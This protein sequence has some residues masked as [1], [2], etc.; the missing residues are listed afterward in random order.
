MTI[1]ALERF[2]SQSGNMQMLQFSVNDAEPLFALIDSNREHLSQFGDNASAKYPTPTSVFQS[3][4]APRHPKR[5]RFGI[6]LE[7]VL[8]GSINLTP[9]SPTAASVGYW[10]G[11]QYTRRG[12]ASGALQ[13]M[14]Q[15]ATAEK[16]Y[17]TLTA[18]THKDNFVS[19][20]VLYRAGFRIDRAQGDAFRWTWE[21]PG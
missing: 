8:A 21:A 2:C 7:G 4:V 5:L 6:W 13:A 16:G 14:M 12:I 19:Q 18:D 3:I 20:R 9:D 15:Y 11:R 10:V 17:K 1:D